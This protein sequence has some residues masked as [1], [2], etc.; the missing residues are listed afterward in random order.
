M[1]S[2]ETPTYEAVAIAFQDRGC[3]DP[4]EA[5]KFFAHY[6]ANGWKQANGRPIVK[7]KMAVAGWILR[8]ENF[9]NPKRPIFR[10]WYDRKYAASLSPEDHTK[11]K[12]F[13]REK[14]YVFGGGPGGQW[15][16]PPNKPR[17]WIA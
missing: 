14:G 17:I 16:K 8:M 13:L 2:K 12:Q 3:T 11:Y 15:V 7:W 5:Q 9:A 1:N 6:E 4:K 10:P